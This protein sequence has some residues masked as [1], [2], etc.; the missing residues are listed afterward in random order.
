MDEQSGSAGSGVRPSHRQRWIDQ[1]QTGLRIESPPQ[2]DGRFRYDD[3]QSRADTCFDEVTAVRR[4]VSFAE[5]D[6]RMDFP[7]IAVHRDI[8]DHR[9]DFDLL[10]NPDV[11]V[12]LRVP[13]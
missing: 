3:F 8:S 6:M 13:V 2:M 7:L 10:V 1:G 9:E 12:P 11:L 5:D 4:A